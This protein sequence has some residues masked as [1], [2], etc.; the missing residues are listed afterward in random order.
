MAHPRTAAI[1]DLAEQLTALE[2]PAV[3]LA[4]AAHEA[5]VRD[6]S[7]ARRRGMPAHVLDALAYRVERKHERL[8]TAWS[9]AL[10]AA[11]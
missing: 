8:I 10:H 2:P 9:D 1:A 6:L 3:R 7:T 4:R 11:H 5:A